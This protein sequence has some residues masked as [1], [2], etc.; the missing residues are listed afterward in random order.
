MIQPSALSLLMPAG[1]VN[2]RTTAQAKT[3]T[4]SSMQT[5]GLHAYVTLDGVQDAVRRVLTS[6]GGRV[7]IAQFP[8]AWNN[9]HIPVQLSHV[10]SELQMPNWVHVLGLCKQVCFL[11]TINGT[12]HVAVKRTPAEV[13]DVAS[14]ARLE[15]HRRR[16]HVSSAAVLDLLCRQLGVKQFEVKDATA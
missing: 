13:S 7:P 6:H 1:H 15:L 12:E 11:E 14:R 2:F 10:A 8:A 5:G 4:P 9:A 16:D 3:A